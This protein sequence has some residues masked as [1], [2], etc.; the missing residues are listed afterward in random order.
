MGRF[1][2][3]PV[4][5]FFFSFFFGDTAFYKLGKYWLWT[6]FCFVL[7]VPVVFGASMGS[8]DLKINFFKR[9]WQIHFTSNEVSQEPGGI[10]AWKVRV[11]RVILVRIFPNSD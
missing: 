8:A 6:S 7:L 9:I 11:F 10:I 1:E 3:N 4:I 2:F 5:W